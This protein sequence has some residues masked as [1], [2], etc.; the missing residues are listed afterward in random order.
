MRRPC[1]TKLGLDAAALRAEILPMTTPT[2]TRRS[3]LKTL[4][5]AAVLGAEATAQEKAGGTFRV[6]S[7]R[8]RQ[9]VVPWCFNP[10]PVP[11]LARHAAAMDLK[12]VELCDP[13]FW[14]ELKQLGLTPAIASSHGFAKGFANLAEHDECV[15]T[16]RKRIDEC[17]AMGVERVITFSGF[18]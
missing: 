5:V 18:R 10:M 14:P 16:L 13:K 2:F 7:G 17:A 12:S 1:N 8:I 6:K 11:E 3:A 9:S 15:A 4:A